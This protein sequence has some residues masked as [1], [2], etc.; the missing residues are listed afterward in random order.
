MNPA[1]SPSHAPSFFFQGCQPRTSLS[2]NSPVGRLNSWDTE[3][4]GSVSSTNG[5][6]LKP[7]RR[8]GASPW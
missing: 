3:S 1:W 5:T 6:S 4:L 7:T 2:C 8:P